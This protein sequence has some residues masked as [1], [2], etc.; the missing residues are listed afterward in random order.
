VVSKRRPFTA[1]VI[2]LSMFTLP[3]VFV[4]VCVIC[5]WNPS[6]DVLY[7]LFKYTCIWSTHTYLSSIPVYDLN[8]LTYQANLYMIYTYIPIKY[9]C[10]CSTHTYLSS[11]PVYD[12]IIL[13]YQ[14]YLYMVK[15]CLPIKYTCIWSTHT[16]LSSIP[17]YDLN[18]LTCQTYL[19]VL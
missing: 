12:V 8:M 9:T 1:P 7:Y 6:V 13:T 18:I 15:I 11:L 14:S 16:Y 17:V 10:I 2:V 4:V 19:C 5:E 3:F